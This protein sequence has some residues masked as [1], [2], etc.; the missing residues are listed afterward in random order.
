M[1]TRIKRLIPQEKTIEVELPYYY[2]HYLM[3]DYGDSII[4][5]KI[6]EKLHTSIHETE[7]YDGKEIY[8]IEK[9]KHILIE[10]STLWGY[11]REEYQS[12]REEFEA[13]KDSCL[14]FLS[15]F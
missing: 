14:L 4:Y 13:V 2:K 15:G 10:N 9:E 3:D 6:E 7:R 12:S 8:E 1:E 11:F 5:G